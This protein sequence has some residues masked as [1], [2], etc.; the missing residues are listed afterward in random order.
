MIQSNTLLRAPVPDASGTGGT[1]CHSFHPAKLGRNDADELQLGGSAAPVAQCLADKIMPA[2]NN[3][4]APQPPHR[5]GPSRPRRFRLRGTKNGLNVTA[6]VCLMTALAG[7]VVRADTHL[8]AGALGTNQNDKLYVYNGYQFD[9]NTTNYAFPQILRTNGLN[10]GYYRGEASQITFAA[11]GATGDNS[12]GQG[13][14]YFTNL[15]GVPFYNPA[16]GS[17]IAVQVVS[18]TGPD[19]GSL[20]F[21]DAAGLQPGS[22]ITFSTPVGTSGGTNCFVI[23]E[24]NGASDSDP[25]GHIHYR[26]FTTTL[27][28]IYVVGFRLIDISTNGLGGGPIHTPSDL[29]TIRLQAGLRIEKFQGVTNRVTVSFRSPYAISNRLEAT[30]SLLQPDWQPVG[31]GVFG[32]GTLQSLSD[33]NIFQPARFYRLRQLNNLP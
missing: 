10:A 32:L 19:G 9:A 3:G 11:L 22:T 21:W 13:P 5:D 4:E 12:E 15:V 23:S 1:R 28:G 20:Q 7:F 31:G 33:T 6:L 30:D 29:L 16:V 24:N 27:P 2:V 26:T 17:R 18:V 25:Y 8:Y 14:I